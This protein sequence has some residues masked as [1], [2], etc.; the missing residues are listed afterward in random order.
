MKA[1]AGVF[2]DGAAA[3]IQ[4]QTPCTAAVPGWAG[5][6]RAQLE[7]MAR[8]LN[9]T[10]R[11]WSG[12]NRVF[13]PALPR[14]G[15]SAL[16]TSA[17][18]KAID[19]ASGA[20]GGIVRLAGGDF[21]SGTLLLKS[22]VCLEVAKGARLL[23]SANLADYP[24]HVA[25]RRTVMDTNMGMNQSLIFAEGCENI[26]IAGEGVIDGRGNRTNFPGNETQGSTPGRP[27]LIRVL[28]SRRVH[29]HR[30]TLRDSP[31][32]AQ[33]YLNCE[34]LL[35]DGITVSN[36][37]NFNNDGLDIDGCRRV[38]VR[39]CS[40]NAEDDALCFKGASQRPTEQV[41]VENCR[42]YTSCN[43]IKFGTDSQG[44][45]R[46]VLVRNV[47]VGGTPDDM[48]ALERRKAD[49]GI[50]WEV[51]DGGTAENL[52]VHDARIVRAKSPIF[53]RLSDRG[54]VK[55]GDPKPGPGHLR[56]IVFEKVTGAD[57]GSRGSM[58]LGIPER[59]I[60]DVVLRDVTLKLDAPRE[61]LPEE[62]KLGEMRDEYPDAHM[63]GEQ[64]PA[65]G[66]WARHAIGITLK[67]VDLT[68]AGAPAGR[69]L[70]HSD[71][72]SFCAR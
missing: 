63:V 53:L 31:C 47:E 33:V 10:V 55:P 51:V 64:S 26:A 25:S 15:S 28:D 36:E 40:I 59:K 22:N 34:D 38:I 50:S 56:R 39:N 62:S 68:S 29:I 72:D 71:V 20:G 52:Y 17:I 24:E 66:I 46:N 2:F 48:P 35:V 49:S 37:V 57:N 70:K 60:E 30:I 23:A 18:Q 43:G 65:W 67:N 6:L 12:P 44:D 1:A 58:I 3:A 19:D 9:Q 14:S 69:M 41:L 7:A 5:E 21:V 16:G 4:A 32:W 54:R 61:A 42:F 45:F 8:R 13:A 11:P 27:F